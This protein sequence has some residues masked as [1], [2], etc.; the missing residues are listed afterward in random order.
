MSTTN[1][2]MMRWIEI[3]RSMEIIA[4]LTMVSSVC[5]LVLIWR[6]CGM[7]MFNWN[8]Q[9]GGSL[10]SPYIW[11]Y[12]A[13]MVPLTLLVVGVWWWKTKETRRSI[14]QEQY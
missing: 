13:A 4:I 11:T 3:G 7:T 10:V 9:P 5:L 8:C 14:Q 6:F 1:A 12:F 2:R